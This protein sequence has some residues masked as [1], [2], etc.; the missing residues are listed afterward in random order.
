MACCRKKGH[1]VP[2][3][4]QDLV[5]PI[6][7]RSSEVFRVYSRLQSE[8]LCL[9]LVPAHMDPGACW[10]TACSFLVS[11]QAHIPG[12]GAHMGCLNVSWDTAEVHVHAEGV[13]GASQPAHPAEPA[14][15]PQ[16]LASL[17]FPATA[18]CLSCLHT[19]PPRRYWWDKV[20]AK[21]FQML[22][23]IHCCLPR[24]NENTSACDP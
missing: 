14:E 22:K 8:I 19:H 24:L 13:G 7:C 15:P 5:Y 6:S 10:S 4:T 3:R 1:S 12:A 21:V 11:T 23:L 16:L 20:T 9:V 2:R 17:P 18:Q